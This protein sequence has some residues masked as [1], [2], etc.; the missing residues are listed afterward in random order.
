MLRFAEKG[1]ED[2]DEDF[3]YCEVIVLTTKP[4][5]YKVPNMTERN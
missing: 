1:F 2:S 5:C 4:L 3:S